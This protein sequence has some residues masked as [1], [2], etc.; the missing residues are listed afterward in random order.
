MLAK[1]YG[2]PRIDPHLANLAKKL[3]AAEIR[4]ADAEA[5]RFVAQQ[6]YNPDGAVPE[7]NL[8]KV[9]LKE[10]EGKA[11]GGNRD[12]QFQLGL[13]YAKGEGVPT[14]GVKAYQWLYTAEKRGH[15]A[16]QAER[17]Q[18]MKVLGMTS[19]QIRA[20]RDLARAFLAKNP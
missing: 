17:K 1:K 8:A 10:L 20:G 13:R 3:S 12:A 6:F 7:G 14:D 5:A 15:P 16:A 4:Q 18:M 11:N 2:Y 9:G 19:S